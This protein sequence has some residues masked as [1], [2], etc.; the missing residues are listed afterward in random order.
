MAN[1]HPESLHVGG[2]GQPG[3]EA[4][5]P[6]TNA[7]ALQQNIS[8]TCSGDATDAGCQT[9]TSCEKAVACRN[10]WYMDLT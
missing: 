7:G 3:H 5:L 1:L 6:A 10:M 4:L 8:L 2:Y 9:W